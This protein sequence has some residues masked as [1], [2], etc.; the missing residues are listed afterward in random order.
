MG[1]GRMLK[2]RWRAVT[3]LGCAVITCALFVIRPWSSQPA[4]G[5]ELLVQIAAVLTAGLTLF[6]LFVPAAP[7]CQASR[8]ES[9]RKR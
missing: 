1:I 5:W 7:R 9:D 3:L 8:E 2:R 4:A 6:G